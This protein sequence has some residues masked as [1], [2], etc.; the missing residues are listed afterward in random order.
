MLAGCGDGGSGSK[1]APVDAVQAKKAQEYMKNY[2]EQMR[3]ENKA[4]ANAKAQPKKSP[5]P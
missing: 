1:T 5:T 4:K 2:G 3:A